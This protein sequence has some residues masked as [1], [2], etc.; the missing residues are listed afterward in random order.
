MRPGRGPPGGL[1]DP[2][3]VIQVLADRHGGAGIIQAVV[4]QADRLLEPLLAFAPGLAREA[5]PLT[6]QTQLDAPTAVFALVDTAFAITTFSH[7][8]LLLSDEKRRN[9]G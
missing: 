1:G 2:Q 8:F 4:D 9:S 3:P 5:Q 7:H 6:L